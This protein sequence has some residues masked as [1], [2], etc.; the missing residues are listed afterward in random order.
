MESL[1][2]MEDPARNSRIYQFVR[3]LPV[4]KIITCN[5]KIIFTW[6]IFVSDTALG[7]ENK[8]KSYI[9]EKLRFIS[10]KKQVENDE[11]KIILSKFKT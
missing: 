7:K 1:V 3:L 9:L 6:L 4:D 11:Y 2:R 5:L 8:L 10:H